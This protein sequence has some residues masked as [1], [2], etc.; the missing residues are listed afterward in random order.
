MTEE[1]AD[2]QSGIDECV[3]RLKSKIPPMEH[4]AL[5]SRV[6]AL[7]NDSSATTDEVIEILLQEFDPPQK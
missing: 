1:Y 5:D 2:A 6:E 3:A 7:R 4:G